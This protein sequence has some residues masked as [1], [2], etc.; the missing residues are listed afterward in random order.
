MNIPFLALGFTVPCPDSVNEMVTSD[1]TIF[2]WSSQE[3]HLEIVVKFG[4]HVTLVE[5]KNMILFDTYILI[6][7]VEGQTLEKVWESYDEDTKA[8]V[9]NQLKKHLPEL[10]QISNGSYIGSANSGSV[11]DPILGSYYVKGSFDSEE[12]FNNA[13]SDAYQSKAPKRHIKNLL[14]GM[15]CQNN[16]QIVF[17]H[18]GLGLQNIMV[19]GKSVSGILDWG[20]SGWYPEDWEFSKALYVWKWQNDWTDYLVQILRQCY[21]EYAVHSFLAETLW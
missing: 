14:S 17:T 11:T 8:H 13:I 12:A 20:F 15:V 19:N 21:A 1:N 9:T 18:G 10:R 7:F 6:A 3:Y 2:N 16:P 4:S 5:A